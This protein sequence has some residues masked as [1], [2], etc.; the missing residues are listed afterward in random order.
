M[1]SKD[2]P[3]LQLLVRTLGGTEHYVDGLCSTTVV[4]EVKR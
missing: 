4:H 3:E 2:G 1:S